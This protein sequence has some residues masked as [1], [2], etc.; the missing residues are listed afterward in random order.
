M[1]DKNIEIRIAKQIVD[2]LKKY[3][4]V[5]TYEEKDILLRK[6]KSIDNAVYLLLT[7]ESYEPLDFATK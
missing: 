2:L 1:S 4:H 5:K 7:N 6:I 3:A